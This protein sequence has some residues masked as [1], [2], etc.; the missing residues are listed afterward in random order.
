MQHVINPGCDALAVSVG[1]ILARRQPALTATLLSFGSISH[2]TTALL[3]SRWRVRT[4]ALD[5]TCASPAALHTPLALSQRGS[6]PP[7]SSV[8]LASRAGGQPPCPTRGLSTY[9]CFMAFLVAWEAF[10]HTP[11]CRSAWGHAYLS[12]ILVQLSGRVYG[13]QLKPLLSLCVHLHIIHA[14]SVA[15]A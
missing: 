11:A 15:D 9:P 3:Y 5:L 7:S 12:C 1:P 4:S 2:P 14:G 6:W 8:I 10:Q 13:L